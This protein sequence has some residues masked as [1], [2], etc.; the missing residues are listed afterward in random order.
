MQ[1]AAL[2]ICISQLRRV[3]GDDP[4]APRFIETVHRRG[5]RFIAALQDRGISVPGDVSVVSFDDIDR[6][7]P[8]PPFLTTIHQPLELI[9]QRAAELLLERIQTPYRAGQ[10]RKH[11]L[12][13]T[14]LVIRHTCR[15]VT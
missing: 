10:A 11:I 13:P 2:N 4:Q 9:G 6:F 12:L 8:R 15:K 7:S 1:E 3:L 5:Y 14:H